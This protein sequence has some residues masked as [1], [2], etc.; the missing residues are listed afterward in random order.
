[1]NNAISYLIC[2]T[3]IFFVNGREKALGLETVMEYFSG[4]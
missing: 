3:A 2:P 4:L 1:M